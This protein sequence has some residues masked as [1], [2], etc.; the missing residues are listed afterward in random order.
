MFEWVNGALKISKYKDAPIQIDILKDQKESY[1]KYLTTTVQSDMDYLCDLM[2]GIIYNGQKDVT[3]KAKVGELYP[4]NVN[5]HGRAVP[6]YYPVTATFY[7]NNVEVAKDVPIMRI[8]YL[9]EYCILNVNGAKKSLI[10]EM[11]RSEEV[12]FEKK[13]ERVV[14]NMQNDHFAFVLKDRKRKLCLNMRK[15][16]IPII[17]IFFAFLFHYKTQVR[18]DNLFTNRI[19]KESLLEN[20]Y[21]TDSAN[22]TQLM[23]T[24]I[25]S[26]LIPEYKTMN[27]NR[28]RNTDAGK[29]GALRTAL[30]KRLTIDACLGQTLS[31]P[32]GNEGFEYKAGTEITSP[33]IDTLKE[34]G[35]KNLDVK[36][37]D[38]SSVSLSIDSCLGLNLAEDIKKDGFFIPAG[39][40][41]TKSL[42]KKM[43]LHRVNEV[44]V[45]RIPNI[46]GCKLA[47]PI[48]IT[49]IPKGSKITEWL[50]HYLP[51]DEVDESMYI[52][53]KDY[54]IPA[55]KFKKG[56]KL[57]EE[58]IQLF[59]DCGFTQLE[60]AV[61]GSTKETIFYTFEQE[62]IGNKTA[63]ARDLVTNPMDLNGVRGTDWVDFSDLDDVSKLK[64]SN[65]SDYFT[66]WDIIALASLAGRLLDGDPYKEAQDVDLDFYKKINMFN[67]IYSKHFRK[68][69]YEFIRKWKGNITKMLDISDKINT[70]DVFK[71]F[72]SKITSSM[73]EASLL[74]TSKDQTPISIIT[75]ANKIV[76]PTKDSSSVS[77]GQRMLALGFFGKIDPN[78]VP[79]GKNIGLVNTMTACCRI[80]DGIMYAPYLK[81]VTTSE[82]KFVIPKE[83][84]IVWLNAEQ[85]R[86]YVIGDRMLLDTDLKGKILN[87]YALARI[88]S[89]EDVSEKMKVALTPI[90]DMQLVDAIGEETLSG[91]VQVMPFACANDSVRVNF[92]TSLFMNCIYVAEG[93]VPY[94]LT[95]MYEH[96]LSYSDE[97]RVKAIDDGYVVSID[98]NVLTV[99]YTTKGEQRY[100]I[101]ETKLFNDCILS[102]NYKKRVGEKFKKGDILVDT[103]VSTDGYYSPGRNLLVAYIPWGTNYED[104]ETIQ[105]AT[106]Y[107]FTSI[108]THTITK[109]I[110]QNKDYKSLGINRYKYVKEQGVLDKI[111]VN[112]TEN[113]ESLPT[114]DWISKV[115]GILY[116]IARDYSD[117]GSLNSIALKA[118]L[119]SFNKLK[120]GDKMSGRHGNKGAV[121]RLEENSLMPTFFNGTIVQAVFNP[122]GISSRMNP[123]QN[124]DAMLGFVGYLLK[125][126]IISNS[127]N[128]ATIE[129]IHYLL[130][131]VYDI[132]N[133]VICDDYLYSFY[134]TNSRVLMEISKQSA[135]IVC[136]LQVVNE[137]YEVLNKVFHFNVSSNDIKELQEYLKSNKEKIMENVEHREQLEHLLNAIDIAIVDINTTMSCLDEGIQLLLEKLAKSPQAEHKDLVKHYKS[138]EDMQGSQEYKNIHKIALI[139]NFTH[140]VARKSLKDVLA[141]YSDLP[142]EVLMTAID[143]FW[144]MKEWENCFFSDGT[145][146]LY[147]PL[148]GVPYEGHVAIG[149]SYLLKIVQEVDEK[150]GAR[151]GML[152]ESYTAL[153]HQANKGASKG[154]GQRTGEMELA[155]LLAFGASDLVFE[156]YN[157]CSDNDGL[158]IKEYCDALGI[159]SSFVD[160][161]QCHP[162]TVD[163]FRY[164]LEGLM[165]KLNITG[166]P[167]ITKDT[168]SKYVKVR[169]DTLFKQYLMDKE[170]AVDTDISESG[171]FKLKD[172]TS[173]SQR[174]SSMLDRIRGIK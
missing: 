86:N 134:R 24:R 7:V 140:E 92:G 145:A 88:P 4:P 95:D 130:K 63:L 165:M 42:L 125:I 117:A 26:N 149:V 126:P 23:K 73:L 122:H 16:N 57:R 138:L 172:S 119:L 47:T 101:K 41:V 37:F 50:M 10:N 162:R 32:V 58:F 60:C 164:L 82:G 36:G 132:S 133:T 90:E 159:D 12:T 124:D 31:R 120:E 150:T 18:L 44:Y 168:V 105:K 144:S 48:I 136:D 34:A 113:G 127:F 135:T 157:I 110:P 65:C 15:Q 83:E 33:M 17:S 38:G 64:E 72:T 3:A 118:K 45:K 11:E 97:F 96:M 79:Q 93:E 156:I 52:T 91:G 141:K 28:S 13:K 19:L 56:T 104:A 2:T 30:N 123:G 137:E 66:S 173:V 55:L 106:S 152:Q 129:D 128:G 80:I 53:T 108:G 112:N 6:R 68:A 77:T 76:T 102:M 78:D 1:K 155:A 49:E 94:V 174:R 151:G 153:E 147:N 131:F 121:A 9:D 14:V 170:A 139:A 70:S 59:A 5:E 143:R 25:L 98:P 158:R 99:K 114:E 22:L 148:N 21:T 171:K 40:E 81:L 100:S 84:Y 109:N 166:Y 161:V 39:T 62:I 163:V 29:L 69:G 27:S 51:K 8:P 116:D 160:D 85:E 35:Y 75:Q 61:P 111:I 107:D 103:P 115:S 154:G 71:E 146:I 89:T 43:K 87:K 46:I 74:R 142:K 20:N 167:D 67:E 169:G 54:K